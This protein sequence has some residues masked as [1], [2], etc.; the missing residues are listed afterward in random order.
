[1]KKTKVIV[2]KREQLKKS[3]STVF[4]AVAVSAVIVMFSLISIRFLWDKKNYN[5]RVISAKTKAR[6][7]IETNL[8]NL[9]KLT[10]QFAQLD[11][12]ATTNSSTILHALPPVYDYASLTTSLNS[13]AVSS[14]VKFNGSSGQ[15]SS[16]DAVISSPVSKPVEIPI[17][18]QVTGS[19]EAIKKFVSNLERS[20]RPIQ[21]TNVSFSGTNDNIQAQIQAT[22]YYQP[23]RSFDVTK[24]EVR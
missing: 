8:E 16:A 6:N 11:T 24:T 3:G 19:Y 9:E 2:S 10:E 7:D 15:D 23:A 20:I 4:I 14:G 17:T 12:S 22:T 21:V 5:D 13:L 18:V 1:M